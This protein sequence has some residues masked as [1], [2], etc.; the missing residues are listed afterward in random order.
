MSVSKKS[1]NYNKE[2]NTLFDMNKLVDANEYHGLN[3]KQQ[4]MYKHQLNANKPK[5]KY[6][7]VHNQDVIQKINY[8]LEMVQ[9]DEN[10][11]YKIF[12]FEP[13][14]KLLDLQDTFDEI[15]D[16]GDPNMLQEFLMNNPYHPEALYALGEYFRLKGDFKEANL[17]MEKLL[18]FFEESLAYE[19]KIFKEDEPQEKKMCILDSESDLDL[20]FMRSLLKF[21]VILLKKSL[22]QT[23]FSFTKLLLR[24]NPKEDPMGGL[25]MIDHVAILSKNFDWFINFTRTFA[26]DYLTTGTTIALYPNI[27]YSLSICCLE[28][29]F[30]HLNQEQATPQ[31]TDIWNKTYDKVFSWDWD[32]GSLCPFFWITIG[33]LLYPKL[34]KDI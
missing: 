18:F 28:K 12:E 8:K 29:Q 25:I 20:L 9:T 26:E 14:K 22:F 15:R 4:R 30:G 10:D 5:K 19:F 32:A 2:L 33:V 16:T 31:I 21:I 3:K 1:F 24:L 27:I 17:L 23:S 11:K 6:H 34:L 7:L 13:A